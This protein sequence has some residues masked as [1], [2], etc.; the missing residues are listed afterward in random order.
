VDAAAIA[1]GISETNPVDSD[2]AKAFRALRS[3]PEAFSKWPIQYLQGLSRLGRVS[4]HPRGKLLHRHGDPDSDFYL[5]IEGAVEVSRILP[6]GHTFVLPY[7][8]PGKSIGLPTVIDNAIAV[9]DARTRSDARLL[10]IGRSALRCY[11]EENPQLIFP[12]AATL[13]ELHTYTHQLLEIVATMPLRQRLARTIAEL[14]DSFGDET[15]EG[16]KVA[17]RVTKD[18]LAALTASSRQRVHVEFGR[19]EA[20]GVVKSGYGSITVLDMKRLGSIK[21]ETTIQR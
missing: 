19:L 21:G 3:S 4:R 5:I 18:D 12:L 15:A 8:G 16:V 11:I 9:F 13:M 6:N 14:C 17:L 20:E 10:H 1:M 7:L 2:A